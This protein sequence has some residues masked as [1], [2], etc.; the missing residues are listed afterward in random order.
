MSKAIKPDRVRY[1]KLGRGGDW[2]EEC[3]RDGIARF[4]FGSAS[5]ERFPLCRAGKWNEL[6]TSFLEAGKDKGTATRFTNESRLFFEDDGTTLWIT[7]AREHLY[8]GFLSHDPAEQHQSSDGVFRRVVGGWRST[9]INGEPLSK[10]R[11]SGAINK[12]AAYRGTT[13]DV[14]VEQYVIRRINGE[15]TAEVEI[16]NEALREMIEAV[17]GMLRLL[18]WHDFETLVGLVFSVSGWR[19]QGDVGGPQKTIDIEITLPTTGE[20]AFVQVKSSTDQA[21][22]DKYVAQFETL[23]YDRMFYIYHSAKKSLAE[24]DDKTITVVGPLKLAEMVVEAGLVSWLI[25]KVS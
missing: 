2:E 4:G 15:K 10:N 7:F 25:R 9:D 11:L 20:R 23:S 1:I 8:W 5:D 24:P 12:L 16:A 13:C 22:L 21:E 6:T 17:V 3:V 19:R 18:T 14:D